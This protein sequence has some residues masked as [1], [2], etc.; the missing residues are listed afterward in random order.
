MSIVRKFQDYN[1]LLF[2]NNI[3]FKKSDL[4]WYNHENVLIDPKHALEEKLFRYFISK[5]LS[6]TYEDG[7][8]YSQSTF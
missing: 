4:R 8:L 1:N 3:I 6:S 2:K 5:I 7:I